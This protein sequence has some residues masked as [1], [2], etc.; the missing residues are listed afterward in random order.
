MLIIRDFLGSNNE[1][2]LAVERVA[3]K[4]YAR[5]ATSAKITAWLNDYTRRHAENP[6]LVEEVN[7]LISYW[8][9]K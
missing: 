2:A 8:K 5:G 1:Q 6:N 4:R 9:N 7:V 3:F